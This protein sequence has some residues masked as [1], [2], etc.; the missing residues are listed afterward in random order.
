V[1]LEVKDTN[2]P[3]TTNQL[4][5]TII[6]VSPS[7]K[8]NNLSDSWVQ[9][10]EQQFPFLDGN[11]LEEIHLPAGTIA[12]SGISCRHIPQTSVAGAY[13]AGISVNREFSFEEVRTPDGEVINNVVIPEVKDLYT[14]LPEDGYTPPAELEE[15]K[16]QI[17]E[18]RSKEADEEAAFLQEL[19]TALDEMIATYPEEA[20]EELADT[21]ASFHSE[22]RYRLYCLMEHAQNQDKQARFLPAL[23]KVMDDEFKWAPPN[24]RGLP[25]LPASNR[26]WPKMIDEIGLE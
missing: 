10:G 12:K 8:A 21:I 18:L 11:T 7:D 2:D 3:D 15:Y 16:Q 9:I 22:G 19:Q 20:R 17:D 1:I 23:R 4:P 25:G 26:G 14:F 13:V 24:V 5:F 6:D